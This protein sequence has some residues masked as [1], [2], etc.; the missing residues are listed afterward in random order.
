MTAHSPARPFRVSQ[1]H[2]WGQARSPPAQW[3]RAPAHLQPSLCPHKAQCDQP[4]PPRDD[5]R[6]EVGSRASVQVTTLNVYSAPH[7]GRSL[8][9]TR[10]SNPHSEAMA[11][12]LLLPHYTDGETEAPEVVTYLGGG[13]V[14]LQSE[15]LA[16]KT[17]GHSPTWLSSCPAP[18][19]PF[20][21]AE[22][23]S[24]GGC[25]GAPVP[26]PGSP[27]TSSPSH[28]PKPA[29]PSSPIL[30]SGPRGSP[31]TT[32]R[33]GQPQ[34]SVVHQ[35]HAGRP[36][37]GCKPAGSQ[38]A[39]AAPAVLGQRRALPCPQQPFPISP[40]AGGGED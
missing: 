37:M 7:P 19:A 4:H 17:H 35:A 22:A 8:P 14:R 28:L 38:Q 27:C 10:A 16:A 11:G 18:V 32:A 25:V 15:H 24:T 5:G 39:W 21:W 36:A 33:E 3:Q 40:G 2:R 30:R 31:K 34:A 23:G 20:A 9:P 1:R 12:L 26:R 6:A 29:P 13:S